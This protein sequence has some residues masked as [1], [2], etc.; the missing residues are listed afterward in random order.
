MY[1]DVADY[2]EARLTTYS[3]YKLSLALNYITLF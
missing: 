3:F 1:I 2:A